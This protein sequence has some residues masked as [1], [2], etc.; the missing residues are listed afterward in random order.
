M[1][2]R[3]KSQTVHSQPTVLDIVQDLA[4]TTSEDGMGTVGV[5]IAM[6]RACG[7]VVVVLF[8][9]RDVALERSS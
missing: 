5:T 3:K 4:E 8:V 2:T 9:A 6:R 1:G 7:L